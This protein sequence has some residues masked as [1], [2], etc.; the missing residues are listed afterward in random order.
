MKIVISGL[1]PDFDIE[2][3]RTRMTH[4]G[5]VAGIQ[6]VREG[7]PDQPWVIVDMGLGVGEAHAMVRRI[8]GI[9]YSDRV[10]RARVLTHG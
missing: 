6:T 3:L 4:F 8:D 1:K 10:L 2:A 5:P 7:D 9:Y